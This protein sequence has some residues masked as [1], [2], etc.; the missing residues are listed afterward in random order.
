[1]SVGATWRRIAWTLR[2]TA[3]LSRGISFKTRQTEACRSAIDLSTSAIR[4]ASIFGALVASGNALLEGIACHA[5]GTVANGVSTIELTK[6]FV[7]TGVRVTGVNG[8]VTSLVGVAVIA[9]WAFTRGFV[10]LDNA[11]GIASTVARRS[12]F[13]V[14]TCL[15]IVTLTIR[16]ASLL[17]RTFDVSVAGVTWMAFAL[18]GVIF[19]DTQRVVSA[20][21]FAARVDADSVQTVAELFWWAILVVL[22]DWNVIFD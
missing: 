12:A 10:V 17:L 1:M 16:F 22:A 14:N 5:F 18:V 20:R 21:V 7:S 19:G 9:S 3:R 6:C 15:R 2:G 4:S 8:H 11:F 13:L